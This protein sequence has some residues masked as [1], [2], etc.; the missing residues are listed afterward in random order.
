MTLRSRAYTSLVCL[1]SVLLLATSFGLARASRAQEAEPAAAAKKTATPEY[2]KVMRRYLEAQGSAEAIGQSIAFGE[3]QQALMA[4]A[5]GGIEITESIQN[6]VLEE[7]L[8]VFASRFGDLDFLAD[9]WAPVY[10]NHFTA[11][12][13]EQM[14]AFFESPVGR[15][16]QQLMPVIN[17]ESMSAIQQTSVSLA[18]AF[19]LAIDARL[20]ETGAAETAPQE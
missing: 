11:Q 7:A 19:Q 13:L 16:S 20:R 15:K 12:E 18:P 1:L 6:I 9:L 14:I 10:V 4:I 17:Q 3:A 5:N 2:R 8:E